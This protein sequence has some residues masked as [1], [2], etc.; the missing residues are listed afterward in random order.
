M[1][2]LPDIARQLDVHYTTLWR[3][4][5]RPGFPEPVARDGARTKFYDVEQVKAW[6]SQHRPTLGR[7][8]GSKV[9]GG[10]VV[11]PH[12]TSRKLW[13]DT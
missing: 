8:V 9:I 1:Q 12:G 7:R 3:W 6:A 10:Q 4:A 5:Q 2:L 11:P 13:W